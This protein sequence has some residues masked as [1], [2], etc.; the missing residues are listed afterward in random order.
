MI[1]K[2]R[3]FIL[4]S[5]KTLDTCKLNL[6]LVQLR[7]D[8]KSQESTDALCLLLNL[9]YA[10]YLRVRDS[11]DR[12]M[13]LQTD[14]HGD[15]ANGQAARYRSGRAPAKTLGL[16]V[17]KLAPSLQAQQR[18]REMYRS[19]AT[20]LPCQNSC[21]KKGESPHPRLRRKLARI[22]SLIGFGRLST[23]RY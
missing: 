12:L 16:R 23:S 18:D 2:T 7:F 19:R 20:K 6:I 9:P 22:V 14:L 21:P 8:G 13:P 11:N 5:V 1:E 3:L 10:P 17:G 4:N 15:P